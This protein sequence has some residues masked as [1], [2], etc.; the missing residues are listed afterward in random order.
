LTS[1]GFTKQK[2]PANDNKKQQNDTL[3]IFH[4]IY[5][6]A[7]IMKIKG[8]VNKINRNCFWYVSSIDDKD[9]E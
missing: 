8:M 5:P 1:Y 6:I 4:K 2:R 3:H 9:E 7:S